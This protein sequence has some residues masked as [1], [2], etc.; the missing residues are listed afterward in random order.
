L[1]EADELAHVLRVPGRVSKEASP[2]A[3]GE[4]AV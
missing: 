1:R 4:D 2:A 3:Q